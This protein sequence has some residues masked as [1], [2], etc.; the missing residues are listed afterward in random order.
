MFIQHLSSWPESEAA[1]GPSIVLRQSSPSTKTRRLSLLL[2]RKGRSAEPLQ[3]EEMNRVCEGFTPDMF[4]TTPPLSSS[5]FNL[6][7]WSSGRAD[8]LS[9]LLKNPVAES[10]LSLCDLWYC[11]IGSHNFKGTARG[12]SGIN[13]AREGN[14]NNVQEILCNINNTLTRA[15]HNAWYVINSSIASPL[16]PNFS[17]LTLTVTV[18]WLS[19]HKISG[20]T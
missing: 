2:K 17:W 19:N 7:D 14:I 11:I 13:H 18:Q 5:R 20:K 12:V 8:C 15:K 9:V 16:G 1:G 6:H 3:E 10:L 4:A